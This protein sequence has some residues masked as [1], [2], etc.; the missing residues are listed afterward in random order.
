M[1]QNDKMRNGETFKESEMRK[2]RPFFTKTI[3]ITARVQKC[4][5][6]EEIADRSRSVGKIQNW[7]LQPGG[8][9]PYR[10][11]WVESVLGPDR[12]LLDRSSELFTPAGACGA[13]QDPSLVSGC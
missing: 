7:F 5:L 1:V 4:V 6:Q 9:V 8:L 3:I 10:A 12:S 2:Q 13:L 11:V